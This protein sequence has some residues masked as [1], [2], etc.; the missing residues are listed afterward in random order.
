MVYEPFSKFIEFSAF[1]P[2]VLQN[3]VDT[4]YSQF[5]DRNNN[6]DKHVQDINEFERISIRNSTDNLQNNLSK[7]GPE[8]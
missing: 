6:S 2:L 1:V 8:K 7:I 5:Q 4:L 3:L